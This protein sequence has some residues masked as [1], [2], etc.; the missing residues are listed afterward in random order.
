MSNKRGKKRRTTSSK[1]RTTKPRLT[2]RPSGQKIKVVAYCDSPTCATGFGT[3]S[4]NVFE[5]LYKTGRYDIDILGINYWGDPHNFPYRIWP[6]GTNAEKDPYGRQKVTNMIPQMDFDL[7]FFLQDSFILE[8]LP[9]LIPHLKKNRAKAFKSIG[10]Y[11]VDSIIKQPWAEN[12]NPIDF[13]VAYSEFGRKETLKRID[14]PDITVIPHGVNTSEYFPIAKEEIDVFK[15]QYFG[16]YADY[17]IITNV[18]RNQQRKDIPRTIAAFKEF[19]KIVPESILY[20]HMSM[21][22]QGWNLVEVCNNMGLDTSK[23]V[24]F[25]KNF[26]PNQGYPRDVLNKLYNCSD[27]VVST[28]LGEGFGLAWMEAMAAKATIVMPANTMLPEFVTDETGYLVDS[29]S[30]PSLWTVIQFDNEV[31]RP[32][33]DVEDL[34]N[35]L[36]E[37]YNN[38]EEAKRRADNAYKWVTTKMDWQKHIAKHWVKIFDKAYESIKTTKEDDVDSVIGQIGKK[39]TIEAEEF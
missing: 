27:V 22:D 3:V 34:T 9:T 10:Y 25:P 39:K 8:F 1:S 33:T 4:R 16:P 38:R 32:L 20:L 18:N 30:T 24:I 21:Q 19:R 29:G 35:T 23:D 17:F 26:G 13:L 15:R 11:P 7:L 5:G 31:E 12:V 14:R 2:A 6:T 37:I 28:T 36:V